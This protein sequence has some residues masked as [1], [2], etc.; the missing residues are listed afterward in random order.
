[1]L[2]MNPTNDPKKRYLT[3]PIASFCTVVLSWF[4]INSGWLKPKKATYYL[5]IP[6]RASCI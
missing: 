6:Y 4:S 1:M 5:S 3:K 2:K